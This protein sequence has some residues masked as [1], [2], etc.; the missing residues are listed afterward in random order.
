MKRLPSGRMFLRVAILLFGLS[1]LALGLAIGGFGLEL[2]LPDLSG[3]S[4][5]FGG[6]RTVVASSALLE[7]V[8]D[9]YRLNTVEY[10]HKAVFPHDFLPLSVDPQALSRKLAAAR[11]QES[12]P[13]TAAEYEY[14]ET[15]S[16]AD[17][18]GLSPEKNP[19]G[20]LIVTV[21]AQAGFE[22][23]SF[24]TGR[25]ENEPFLRVEQTGRERTV[26]IDLPDPAITSLVI[27]DP[28]SGE[29]RYPDVRITPSQW[30]KL[31]AFVTR[32]VRPKLLEEGILIDAEEQGRRAV[33]A[34]L[35][36]AGFDR[37]VVVETGS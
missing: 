37:V 9:L 23:E 18:I 30:R 13:L 35:E 27:D 3:L 32:R 34:F 28:S 33:T 15:G 8:R 1:A 21:T 7:Q 14:L 24:F 25:G 20:F 5:L 31:A 29:Y 2:R 16:L 22:L 4:Q 26:Y 6:E 10:V 36:Q 11:T 12:V 17:E 19:T